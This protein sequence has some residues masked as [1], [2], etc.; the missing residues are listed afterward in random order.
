MCFLHRV[1]PSHECLD[2]TSSYDDVDKHT[3]SSNYIDALSWLAPP[4][5]GFI[6]YISASYSPSRLLLRVDQ[7]H[8]MRVLALISQPLSSLC[9]PPP[10]AS[11][12]LSVGWLA[13]PHEGI[14]THKSASLSVECS[15]VD[16][17]WWFLIRNDDEKWRCNT[18]TNVYRSN[19]QLRPC[20]K[21]ERY[22][23]R[24]H[25][26]TIYIH[27][28]IALNSEV[29]ASEFLANHEYIYQEPTNIR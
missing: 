5:E 21:A 25:D 18:L 17:Y 12:S 15:Y 13:P 7:L 2:V 4:H 26:D 9:H 8:H 11:L 27:L 14:N 1:D 29:S 19:E 16:K 23:Q 22:T 20:K 10:S 6:T 24:H 28:R 3:S